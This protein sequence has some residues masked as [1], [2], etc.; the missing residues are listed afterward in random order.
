M[1]NNFTFSLKCVN[2]SAN[3]LK[4]MKFEE[5]ELMEEVVDPRAR[6]LGVSLIAGARMLIWSNWTSRECTFFPTGFYRCS[7]VLGN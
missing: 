1:M 3:A 7:Q 6:S 4:N 2:N 5:S